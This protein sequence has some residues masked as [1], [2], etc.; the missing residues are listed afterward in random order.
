MNKRINILMLLLTLAMGV[1]AANFRI[2]CVGK[3]TQVVQGQD[4]IFIFKD[5]PALKT[6]ND[7]A[8]NWYNTQDTTTAIASNAKE[9]YTLNSGDGVAVRVG[10]RWMVRYVFWYKDIHPTITIPSVQTHCRST[11]VT[12][13]GTIPEASYR[14]LNGQ[15]TELKRHHTASFTSLAWAGEAWQDSLVLLDINTLHTG[16]NVLPE[17]MLRESTVAIC[18][19]ADW[20]NALSIAVDSVISPLTQPTA[21]SS[22]PTSVTTVRGEKGERSNEVERPVEEGV[23]TGSAPLDILFKSNPTPAV[24]FYQW[25]IY[26]GTQL[27]VNRTDQDTRYT[28]MEPGQYRV[29]GAVTNTFCPCQDQ[30]DP[31]CVADSTEFTVAVS[32]SYILVPNAFSPNGDGKNDEFRVEYRSIKEFHCWVY[33]RWGK[34]VY[35]WTDPAKGWDGT[36]NGLPAPEGAYFYVI[37]AMGTDAD[38][39]AK[40]ISQVAYKKKDKNEAQQKA[41]IGVYQLAGDINLL[42]GK[43]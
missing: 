31:D 19:D 16:E 33:N 39:N 20:A 15:K 36:I 12:V 2:E 35:E 9:I 21:I 5:A 13:E 43:K 6:S 34:L 23:L 26:K 24:E 37:R 7:S 11:A 18:C 25:R 38:K 29:V 28:F 14:T 41:I 8:V 22:Y 1:S 32:E 27:I 4:T 40:F 3:A 42:R 30:T 17:R 10:N